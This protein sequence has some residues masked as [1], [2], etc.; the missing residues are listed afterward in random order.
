MLTALFIEDN[1]D[2]RHGVTETLNDYFNDSICI[3]EASNCQQA[4]I[5]LRDQQFDLILLD[6]RI[7]G[8]SGLDMIPVIRALS[9]R[10]STIIV[11][12]SF[13]IPEYE[14]YVLDAGADAYIAKCSNCFLALSDHITRLMIQ[15]TSQDSLHLH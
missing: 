8:E 6:L 1:P 4:S 5:M 9:R 3:Y 13:D 7:S 2:F 15:K 10:R 14:K 11:L 12:S